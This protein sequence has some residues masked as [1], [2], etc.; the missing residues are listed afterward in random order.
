MEF[1]TAGIT[2]QDCIDMHRLK[3]Q[4]TVIHNGR[5]LGFTE[6][7]DGVDEKTV[8]TLWQPGRKCYA[9]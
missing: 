4:G 2:I 8:E 1:N 5:V 9:D 6:N 3:N 7:K